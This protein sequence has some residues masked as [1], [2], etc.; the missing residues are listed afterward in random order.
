[1]PVHEYRP[2]N[3]GGGMDAARQFLAPVYVLR[4][5]GRQGIHVSKKKNIPNKDKMRSISRNDK[6]I[7]CICITYEKGFFF[8]AEQAPTR[9][10]DALVF[11]KEC[12]PL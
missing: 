1:M 6:H 7:S 8:L 4:L 3:G 9:G 10:R 5:T 2:G 12:E 11:K